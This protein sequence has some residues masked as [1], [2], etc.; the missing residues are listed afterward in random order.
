VGDSFDAALEPTRPARFSMMNDPTHAMEPID[1][2]Q[3]DQT[4]KKTARAA[5][6]FEWSSLFAFAARTPSAE[7]AL[8]HL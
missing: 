6:Y 2:L 3:L 1:A 7:K 4:L 8:F 5:F